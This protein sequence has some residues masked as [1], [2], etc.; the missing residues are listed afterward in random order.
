MFEDFHSGMCVCVVRS[1]TLMVCKSVGEQLNMGGAR[2]SVSGLYQMK[3]GG[4]LSPYV[5]KER[6]KII[7]QLVIVIT[8]NILLHVLGF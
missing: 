5:A 7:F 1:L 3:R 8:V 2:E 6:R 4:H